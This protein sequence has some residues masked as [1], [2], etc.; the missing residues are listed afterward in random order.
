MASSRANLSLV[1]PMDILISSVLIATMLGA[2]FASFL[3]V[4]VP[5]LGSGETV[6]RGRSRCPHC[7]RKLS[8]F[9]LI[10]IV[11]YLA[12][13][14]RCR[15]CGASIPAWYLFAEFVLGAGFGLLAMA[16]PRGLLLPPPFVLPGDAASLFL[17][18]ATALYYAT[19]LWFAA[20]ISIYDI[21]HRLI[22][23][24]LA[25]PLALLGVA[26]AVAG[27][28]RSGDA[29]GLFI[30]IAAALGAFLFFWALWFFSRGRA[31]GRGDADVAFAIV[32][33]L[34]PWGG[35]V[36][37][38]LGFWVG[39]LY[40]ILVLALGRASWKTEIPFAPF[41]FMGALIALAASES[42][43]FLRTVW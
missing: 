27:A 10:P 4:V 3:T 34:G 5:R 12:Q 13:R 7:R 6:V 23:S 16:S 20:A 30:S 19:F 11:S 31:M 17:S 15:S 33:Y 35:A 2:V 42:F 8:W 37:L 14:G 28:I 41:L 29:G 18:G 32:A 9:E 39:A 24:V 26:A 25:W 43:L 1:F 40:G 21:Q 36:A 22:P 38:L